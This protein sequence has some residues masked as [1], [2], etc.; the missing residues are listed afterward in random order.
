MP[1]VATLNAVYFSLYL[2]VTAP[3]HGRLVSTSEVNEVRVTLLLRGREFG[4]K[5]TFPGR[6]GVTSRE[7]DRVSGISRPRR[8]RQSG[9]RAVTVI[10][11]TVV[12]SLLLGVIEVRVVTSRPRPGECDWLREVSNMPDSDLV[13]SSDPYDSSLDQALSDAT[14]RAEA[15]NDEVIPTRTEAR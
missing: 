2:G 13:G 1:F 5:R 14:G 3:L 15:V 4:S 11:V 8:D 7:H 6:D 12:P 10:D 9:L